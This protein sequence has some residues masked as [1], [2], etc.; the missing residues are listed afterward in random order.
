[1]NGSFGL[2]VAFQF[3]YGR[4]VWVRFLFASLFDKNSRGGAVD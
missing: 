2:C 3:E 1:L 4:I